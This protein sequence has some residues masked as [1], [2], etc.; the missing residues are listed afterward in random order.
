MLFSVAKVILLQ[1]W[2]FNKKISALKNLLTFEDNIFVIIKNFRKMSPH[3]FFLI[4][5]PQ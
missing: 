4:K 1:L 5:I 3:V 2:N